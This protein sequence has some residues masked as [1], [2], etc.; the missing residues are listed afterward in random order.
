MPWKPLRGGKRFLNL[1][2]L[3]DLPGERGRFLLLLGGPIVEDGPRWV[4]FSWRGESFAVRDYL[5]GRMMR[6]EKGLTATDVWRAAK[7]RLPATGIYFHPAG[8]VEWWTDALK[9]L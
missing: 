6:Q 5:K 3:P 9:K 2:E 7:K 1:T 4:H 8:D